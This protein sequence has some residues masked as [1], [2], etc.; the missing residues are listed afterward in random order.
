MKRL[1]SVKRRV[2]VTNNALQTVQVILRGYR[3]KAA[4]FLD[5]SVANFSGVFVDSRTHLAMSVFY[6]YSVGSDSV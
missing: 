1:H 3:S 2:A 5:S 6:F 4:F